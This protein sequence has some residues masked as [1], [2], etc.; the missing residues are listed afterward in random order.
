MTEPSAS[1][2]VEQPYYGLPSVYRAIDQKDSLTQS[3][4]L[5]KWKGAAPTFNAVEHLSAAWLL[6]AR[7]LSAS[8][9]SYASARISSDPGLSKF[10]STK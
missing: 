5:I 7:P 8:F 3:Q 10:S 2:L 4:L 9:P 1:S 6:I